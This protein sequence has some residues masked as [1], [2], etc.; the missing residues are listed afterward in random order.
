MR[1]QSIIGI[2]RALSSG[3]A[4]AA[5]VAAGY[6]GTAQ[7]FDY[8]GKR[9]EFVVPFATGG[10]SD[11]WARFFAPRFQAALPGNPVIAVMNVRIWM[12]L[13]SNLS[14]TAGDRRASARRPPPPRSRRAAGSDRFR[15]PAPGP[16]PGSRGRSRSRT[17]RPT[18][19][20]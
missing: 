18:P 15:E 12:P 3:L 20:W 19:G 1:A 2:S 13:L 17:G 9:I 16:A 11:N 5:I 4:V 8:S 6:H 7:A 14:E 10:G